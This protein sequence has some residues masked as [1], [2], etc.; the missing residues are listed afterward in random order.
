[1][2]WFDLPIPI[3]KSDIGEMSGSEFFENRKSESPI[4]PFNLKIKI[5]FF[6]ENRKFTKALEG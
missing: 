1:M 3:E 5:I 2:C 4:Y 6:R